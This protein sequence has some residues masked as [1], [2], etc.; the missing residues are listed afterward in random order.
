MQPDVLYPP[1]SLLCTQHSQGLLQ[2]LILR[3]TTRA[4]MSTQILNNKGTTTTMNTL[5]SRMQTNGM[6]V[7]S[8]VIKIQG[9]VSDR[10]SI[11]RSTCWTREKHDFLSR[12]RLQR[13]LPARRYA[14]AG[15]CDSDVSVRPS[16]ARRY[17][18]KTVH[19]RHKVTMGR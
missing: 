17:C 11:S 13:F 3:I 12:S 6:A 9:T 15:L 1:D 4:A 18:A 14:S 10:T 19:F 16:A 8:T 5:H 7:S 2:I